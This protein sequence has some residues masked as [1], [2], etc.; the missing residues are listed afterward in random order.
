M[1]KAL[2]TGAAGFIGSNVVRELLDEGVDVRAMVLPGE[3][4][5]N[6]AG[7]DVEKVPGNILDPPSLDAALSGCDTLFHLAALYS[8]HA[9]RR[10]FF[11]VNLQGSRNM[12]WAAKKADLEKIVYTA[13]IAALGLKAGKLPSDEETEFNQYGANDYVLTKYMSQQEALTFAREGMPIVVVNPC[14]PYGEGDVV[15]TPTGKVILDLANQ[16]NFMSYDGGY[17]IVDVK[18]VARGHVL[19]AKKGRIGEKYILGNR[20]VTLTELFEMVTEAA[21]IRTRIIKMPLTLARIYGF[22]WEKNALRT[23]TQPTVTHREVAYSHKWLFYDTSKAQRELG[24]EPTPVEVSLERA[25]EWFRREG[26]I[27]RSD[28]WVWF[29]KALMKVCNI[30]LK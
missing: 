15:P 8:L 26:Y 13:S 7:V 28:P 19:A 9:P 10:A 21:G 14:F 3:D 25:I 20:N 30:G 5:R 29:T 4:E 22:L 6:L 11:D 18:D 27:P 23:G 2:V 12:L 16:A 17:N 24:L 1:Q